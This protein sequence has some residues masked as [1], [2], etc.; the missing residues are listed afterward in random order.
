[1]TKIR[2][3]IIIF[4]KGILMWACDVIPWVSWGTIAVITWIY[5]RLIQAIKNIIPNLKLFFT[6]NWKVFRK[7]IDWTFLFCLIL[8]IWCSFL[9]LANLITSAMENQPILIRSFFVWL[10]LISAIILWTQVKWDW[11]SLICL[12]IFSVLAFW[13]TSPSNAPLSITSTWR[14]TFICG[15]VAICAMILPGIS[16]SFILVLLWEYE[17]M[18]LAIKNFDILPICIFLVWALIW[19]IAFSNVLSWLFKHFKMITLASLT[20][21][22]L[23]SLNKIWPR[24][25]TL[26]STLW[27]EK[28]ILPWR[29]DEYQLLWAFLCFLL[30]IIVVL[31]IE[32]LWNKFNK[33]K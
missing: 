32:Y 11:K 8:W 10:I 3:H 27:T 2:N 29:G 12:I 16:G 17:Y 25:Q 15:V 7:N 26:D 6:G 1:M 13:I 20:G 28:N 14:W 21:F 18:M 9:C 24:K 23:W 30:W 5:E 22:M 4:L 33:S 31:G 19:I